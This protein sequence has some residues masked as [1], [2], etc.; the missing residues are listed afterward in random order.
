[1]QVQNDIIDTPEING[2]GV[3]RFERGIPGFEEERSFLLVPL[4]GKAPFYFL[5]SADNP[6]LRF[7]ACEPF[8]LLSKYEVE[9]TEKD[10]R[11]LLLEKEEDAFI[12]LILTPAERIQESTINLK[13]PVVIN[14][15]KR[16]AKQVILENDQYTTRHWLN[17]EKVDPTNSRTSAEAGRGR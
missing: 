6:L 11:D 4:D 12:L 13:A 14:V 2:N 3:I 16:L 9:L 17:G 15:K 10:L 8:R 7:I 1:M 5:Q